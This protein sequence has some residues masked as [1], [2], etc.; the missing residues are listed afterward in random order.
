MKIV[1]IIALVAWSISLIF[2]VV[3]SRYYFTG[4]PLDLIGLALALFIFWT[5]D[6]QE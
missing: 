2:D 4:V 6:K 1:N 5:E 3:F